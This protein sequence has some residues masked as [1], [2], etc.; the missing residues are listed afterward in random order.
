[1]KAM[2]SLN[3]SLPRTLKEFVEKQAEEGGYSTPSEYVRQ[4]VREDQRRSAQEKLEALILE[5]L[6]S[7]K[8]LEAD[9][10]FWKKKRQGILEQHAQRQRNP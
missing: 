9:S 2:T 4:L 5:G 10:E 6:Q 3:I 8:S 1:M 7:G